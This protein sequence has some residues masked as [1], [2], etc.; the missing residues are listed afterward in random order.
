MKILK[1]IYYWHVQT[2]N[3][4]DHAIKHSIVSAI[5]KK[6][7]VP[8][9]FFNVKYDEL[10]E[11]RIINDLNKNASALFIAGSG[12]YSNCNTKSGWYFNCTSELFQKSTNLIVLLGLGCNNN[13]DKD[14]FGGEL[15]AKAKESIKLI[16][17][18]AI[19]STV[20]D[21][22]TY[23][24][25]K[26][27][28]VKNHQLMLDP[29]CFLE[30]PKNI[31][32]EKRIAINIAQHSP[33]LGR[34]DGGEEGQKNREKHLQLFANISNWLISEGY[35]VVFIA[36]DAL[37]TSLIIDLKRQVPQ[38]EWVNTDDI[39]MILT[40]YSQCMIT[41]CIKMHSAIMSFAV[42]TPSIQLYY[43]QK[44]I[45]FLKMIDCP[46]LGMSIFDSYYETFKEKINLLLNNYTYYQTKIKNIK[47]CEQAKFNKII[48][49]ICYVIENEQKQ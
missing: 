7:D 20:R 43:D 30:A 5:Q 28:G 38:L 40:A 18:L 22:R 1:P 6:I 15:S 26:E 9:A 33:L 47:Q 34:Y 4:G 3:R 21:K 12:L 11:S 14:I 36:H 45:E 41:I 37:E 49:K 8:F 48:N 19:I 2:G 23:N 31:K 29:A 44:A 39:D 13:L 32:R 46:E 42:G 16:N 35:S 17:D 25:L 27:I 24:I 10:T